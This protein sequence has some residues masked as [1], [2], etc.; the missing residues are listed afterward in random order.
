VG[1]S[2]A[3]RLRVPPGRYSPESVSSSRSGEG[4]SAGLAPNPG[5]T[6]A[7]TSPR[8]GESS[9]GH[10][11]G[12]PGGRCFG[13]SCPRCSHCSAVHRARDQRV[14]NGRSGFLSFPFVVRNESFCVDTPPRPQRK[15]Q[16]HIFGLE[17]PGSSTTSEV[18]EMPAHQIR[19]LA[20]GGCG[21]MGQFAVR[22][23]LAMFAKGKIDRRGVFAPEGAIDPDA[24]FRRTCSPLYAEE[25]RRS[26]TGADRRFERGG[27]QGP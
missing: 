11:V 16:T 4:G 20:L 3:L 27:R 10:D 5:F 2:L 14:C 19:V 24:F 23:A 8:D 18:I 15:G 17:Q 7:D 13:Q 12:H 26:G 9:A 6:D 22:T 21:G 25:E 1:N